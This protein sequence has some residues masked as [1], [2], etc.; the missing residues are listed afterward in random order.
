MITPAAKRT[1]AP[2]FCVVLD[3]L[4]EALKNAI[5][6][7]PI[8]AVLSD[9]RLPGNPIVA[10]NPAFS[11]LT[12]FRSEEIIGRNCRFLS[13]PGTEP[14]LTERISRSVSDRRP[15]LVDIL[16][17][18]RD[19]TPFRN[20]VTI[21]PVF[22]DQGLLDYFMG[23]QVECDLNEPGLG[24]GRRR[25]A[26]ALVATLSSRQKDVLAALAKGASSKETAR[27]LGI[28]DK[29][30]K[31]HRALLLRKLQAPGAAEAIRIA[32]EAGL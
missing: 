4:G 31:M 16:N 2:N 29:T 10:S 7:S 19:G 26:A 25:A 18:R 32:V 15:V 8:A 21:A 5:E 22:S 11:A 28:S 27:L 20:A 23:S 30:V 3:T 6:I 13:G 17:Y 9:P 1:P 12:G 24:A 14:W